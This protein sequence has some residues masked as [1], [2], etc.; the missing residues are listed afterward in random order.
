MYKQQEMFMQGKCHAKS[1][2][3][4]YLW[5]SRVRQIRYTIYIT[6]YSFCFSKLFILLS[7]AFIYSVVVT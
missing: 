3:P 7:T 6:I 5:F 2:E 1:Q 4:L